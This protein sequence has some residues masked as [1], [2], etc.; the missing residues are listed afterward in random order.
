[1]SEINWE[2]IRKQLEKEMALKLQDLPNHRQVRGDLKKFRHLI[3]HQLPETTSVQIFKQL[4]GF[5]L[6]GRP[7]SLQEIKKKYLN[8]QL[9]KEKRLLEKFKVEF[10][11]L[12]RLAMEWVKTNLSEKELKFLWKK[13]KTWLPR[14]YMIY[15]DEKTSF[16]KIA[17]DTLARYTLMKRIK[18][19]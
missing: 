4:I 16:Q 18:S 3:S 14:R 13:H 8:P 11:S 12:R 19:A 6:E 9:E 17:A 5:L 15:G 10:N 7:V 1:M 2:R